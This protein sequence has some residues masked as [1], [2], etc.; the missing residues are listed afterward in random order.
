MHKLPPTEIIIP[1]S[2]DNLEKV[3]TLSDLYSCFLFPIF[4]YSHNPFEIRV[5]TFRPDKDTARRLHHLPSDALQYMFVQCIAVFKAL[6]EIPSIPTDAVDFSN[7]HVTPDNSVIFPMEPAGTDNGSLKHL[8]AHFQGSSCFKSLDEE[9]YQSFFDRLCG[10]YRFNTDRDYMYRYHLFQSTI[11]NAYHVDPLKNP[12]VI[13]V[14][15]CTTSII[16]ESIIRHNLLRNYSSPDIFLLNACNCREN[17]SRFMAGKLPGDHVSGDLPGLINKLDVFLKESSSKTL[18]LLVD[19][20]H[21]AEDVQLLDILL[22]SSDNFSIVLVYFNGS[23]NALEFDLELKENPRN[24]LQDFLPFSVQTE[25]TEAE[26]RCLQII[27]V[28]PFLLP[29]GSGAGSEEPAPT[30]DTSCD[31]G[32][33]RGDGASGGQLTEIGNIPG[34]QQVTVE[35]LL[36]AGRLKVTGGCLE[37]RGRLSTFNIMP[38]KEL[39]IEILETCLKF[40]NVGKTTH[41]METMPRNVEVDI[42]DTHG[43]SGRGVDDD[44]GEATRS[45]RELALRIKY[46]ITSANLSSLNLLLR[47]YLARGIIRNTGRSL[48]CIGFLDFSRIEALVGVHMESLQKNRDSLR[49]LLELLIRE[50]RVAAAEEIIRRNLHSDA[51]FM[52]LKTARLHRL[53]K[54]QVAMGK[55]L[56]GLRPHFGNGADIPAIWKDEYSYLNYIYC[57]KVG[58]TK[59]GNGFLKKIKDPLFIHLANIKLSDRYIYKREFGKAAKLLEGVPA[60]LDIRGLP[61]DCIEAGS[62]MAKLLREKKRFAE[63]EVLYKKLYVESKLNNFK[64]QAAYIASDLGNCYI[65]QDDYCRCGQWYQKALDIFKALDNTNG[66]N[67]VDS[68]MVELAKIKGDWGACERVLRKELNF[69]TDRKNVDAT[70]IDYFNIAH[71]EYLRRRPKPASNLL[72]KAVAGFE[73]KNNICNLIQCEILKIKLYLLHTGETTDD[74]VTSGEP[75]PAF[76]KKHPSRLRPDQS[77]LVRLMEIRQAGKIPG[78]TFIAE[79]TQKVESA[80]LRFE[81]FALMSEMSAPPELLEL[82][83]VLSMHL[84]PK[85]K[86]YFY[87]QYHYL[88]FSWLLREADNPT[89]T[90][91]EKER[92]YEVYYFFKRNNRILPR[93][94]EKLKQYMDEL[95]WRYHLFKGAELEEKREAWSEP[96]DFF[97]SLTNEIRQVVPADIICLGIYEHDKLLFPFSTS[98]RFRELTTEIIA[99]TF[100][101]GKNRRL[102]LFDIKRKYK[103]NDK[104]FYCYRDNTVISWKISAT[105]QAVLLLGFLKIDHFDIDINGRIGQLLGRF[106]SQFGDFYRNEFT[107]R[108]KLKK[109]I[110]NSPVMKQVKTKILKVGKVDFPLLIRGESGSG[111][112]L[113]AKGVHEA[114]TRAD[115]PFV[116]VNAA[117][118]PG[119]LLE[120]ELFGYKKGAFSG[121]VDSKIGLIRE[122]HH[123]TLFLDEIADL[124]IELQ[125]KLLRVLQESEITPL[126]ENR[127]IAV[128]FRLICATNK[129]I[130]QL[131][132]EERFRE[133]LLYRLKVLTLD[134]PPLRERM[135]DIPLLV[136]HFL[137]QQKF[138]IG[139]EAEMQRICHYFK[140]RSWGGNVRELQSAVMRLITYYPDFD[141][142]T[143]STYNPQ[144]GLPAARENLERSMIVEALEQHDGSKVRAAEFLNISRQHL[145]T[146]VKR[147]NIA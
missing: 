68:N 98:S 79:I 87:F 115:G 48:R 122:A 120:A 10:T 101:D 77:L 76:L 117:A 47:R 134:V 88:C 61:G 132:A 67:L 35:K 22:N 8:L 70:A 129:D 71:L 83:K 89:L 107:L 123:G 73:K 139:D 99:G 29:Y 86:N 33:A 137:A 27:D 109:L 1:F 54:E 116:A 106:F 75:N 38:T 140:N 28:L 66:I 65:L 12:A 112:E 143:G 93:R 91:T 136:R 84:S 7:I 144:H 5:W 95:D 20:L 52:K 119:G 118:I 53:K 17:L 25:L 131:V 51:V 13:K 113:V 82:L 121:A 4:H 147:Y 142:D 50:N 24:L 130:K 56:Q 105:F 3:S 36:R 146:L 31:V 62:Q 69:D 125:A 41:D 90:G 42:P 128:D 92:F 97:K 127:P 30:C 145:A 64:L 141:L 39:E 6:G 21:S 133:D 14:N 78:L 126:G 72:A 40:Y 138:T 135:Q 37:V 102:S 32:R 26:T 18:V 55:V 104:A 16:Q 111:K 100:G 110:G 108:N 9:N 46:Y 58:D 63:A 80:A 49:L 59:K 43:V 19:H 81:I 74:S 96:V 45:S 57:E 11:L 34:M 15:I 94:M 124:P 2:E 85:E 114:G 103:S 60:Y 44:E 23:C